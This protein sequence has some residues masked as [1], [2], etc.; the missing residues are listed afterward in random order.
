MR[1][2][3][4]EIAFNRPQVTDIEST[5]ESQFRRSL[6]GSRRNIAI[7]VGS[8]GIA[9]IARIV[10][11]TVRSLQEFGLAPFI[12]PAMGSHGGAT[13]EGQAQVLASYRITEHEMGCPIRSS[14]EVV[15]LPSENLPHALYM[16]RHAFEAEGILLINRIKPH[17][18]FHGAYESGLVKMSVI[19]LGKERQAIALHDFG[20]HGLRDLVPKAAARLLDLRKIIAGLAIVENAYD[21]TARLELIP[22]HEILAREPALLDEARQNMPRLPV[23]NIHVLIVDEL[24]KNIS[25]SGMDTN[26][27]GRIRIPGEPEPLTPRIH[28]IVVDDLTAESHGNATGLG[29]ADVVTRRFHDKIDFAATYR[30]IITSSFLERGKIPVVAEN[31]RKACEIALRSCGKIEPGAERI[32]RIR[33]TLQLSHLYV[34]TAIAEQL[35]AASNVLISP[36][37]SELF[38]DGCLSRF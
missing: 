10:K 22:A 23:D 17:T 25:G 15:Q 37:T 29:L 21:E 3:K 24:G 30:N 5:I 33:N 7:A 14:M 35:G 26:I 32:I 27:I 36:G 9:N 2:H 31:A 28:A 6:F 16:D 12:I 11:Q 18:D 13:A 20:V 19:G 4:A 1:L 34:S 38:A 8:R